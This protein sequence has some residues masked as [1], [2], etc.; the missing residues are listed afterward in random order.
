[1]GE[2][3]SGTQK[4]NWTAC[5]SNLTTLL[6]RSR[7]EYE[8]VPSTGEQKVCLTGLLPITSRPS[9]LLPGTATTWIEFSRTTPTTLRCLLRSLPRSQESL[10][11]NSKARKQ[12]AITGPRAS[13]AIPICILSWLHTC[14]APEQLPCITKASVAWPPRSWSL[15]RTKKWLKPLPTTP[16]DCSHSMRQNRA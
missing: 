1:M 9:G 11:E 2:S 13:S 14:L 16:A 15:V 4:R 12:W 10:R 8:K 3:I 5:A 7:Q 6:E